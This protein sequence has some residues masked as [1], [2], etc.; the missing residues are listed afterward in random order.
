MVKLCWLF[1]ICKVAEGCYINSTKQTH[2]KRTHSQW[3]QRQ[4]MT[5]QQQTHRL[6]TNSNRSRWV[7]GWIKYTLLAEF[8]MQSPGVYR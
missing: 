2:A 8:E 4:T 6:K 7:E 5:K 1:I 3:E